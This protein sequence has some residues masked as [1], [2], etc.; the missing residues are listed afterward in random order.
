MNVVGNGSEGDGERN[1]H[2]D[3]NDGN[4][5]QPSNNPA[6]ER[7]KYPLGNERLPLPGRD[8]YPN[9]NG[10]YDR[11]PMDRPI[12]DNSGVDGFS[13]GKPGDRDYERDRFPIRD[14]PYTP[15]RY[16]MGD[17][18]NDYRKLKFILKENYFN[19]HIVFVISHNNL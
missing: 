18:P 12:L 6:G 4:W 10:Q 16:P 15:H 8:R 2:P 13:M 11:Y 19:K 9:R 1:N 14:R 17:I 5:R 3:I 7:D